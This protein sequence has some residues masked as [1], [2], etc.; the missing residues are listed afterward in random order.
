MSHFGASARVAIC[1]Y[2]I[3]H[4][5]ILTGDNAGLSCTGPL[6]LS[7]SSWYWE[8][9]CRELFLQDTSENAC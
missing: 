1:R 8:T 4:V 6:P 5:N 7:P 2:I 9:D 3:V